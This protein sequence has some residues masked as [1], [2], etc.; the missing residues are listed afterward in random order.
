MEQGKFREA[1]AQLRVFYPNI[2]S[3][4]SMLS[5]LKVEYIMSHPEP[6]YT[7][8]KKA[9]DEDEICAATLELA[10]RASYP[11]L[12]VE[13][14]LT[15]EEQKEL[16]A[17]RKSVREAK[18]AA[19]GVEPDPDDHKTFDV[20]ASETPEVRRIIE[21]MRK[22]PCEHQES[23]FAWLLVVSGRRGADIFR[24]GFSR[25][26]NGDDSWARIISPSKNRGS[27]RRE[28]D[29]PLVG[30]TSAEFT[31]AVA[32]FRADQGNLFTAHRYNRRL[33]RW[34]QSY[35]D[36]TATLSAAAAPYRTTS[37]RLRKLYAL[38][39]L[40]QNRTYP[41]SEAEYLAKAFGH[42]SVVTTAIYAPPSTPLPAAR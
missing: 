17:Q 4:Q 20:P 41:L 10:R 11:V 36:R 15:P 19:V 9:F 25:A 34:L 6:G 18:Q 30:C 3:F 8:A 39:L 13:F 16:D 14:C 35:V 27:R 1:R 7:V 28:Y 31:A 5:R 40:R 37:H 2:A 12:S 29:F 24:A 23:L 22:E 42:S 21:H 26:A 33:N 32:E 38:L